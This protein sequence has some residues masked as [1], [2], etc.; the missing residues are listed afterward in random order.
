M[1][2]PIYKNPLEQADSIGQEL[3]EP[4]KSSIRVPKGSSVDYRNKVNAEYESFLPYLK[5]QGYQTE[6]AHWKDVEKHLDDLFKGI[7]SDEELQ[8]FYKQHKYNEGNNLYNERYGKKFQALM[9]MLDKLYNDE[10][11][12]TAPMGY[13]EDK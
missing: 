13:E 5:E 1:A 6:G 11:W 3:H 2:N 8:G 7:E 4:Y 12:A 9:S 10:W